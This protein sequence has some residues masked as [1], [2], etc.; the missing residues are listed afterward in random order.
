[1]VSYPELH[2]SLQARL[3]GDQQADNIVSSDIHFKAQRWKHN[4]SAWKKN[5]SLHQRGVKGA[6]KFM[7]VCFEHTQD[8]ANIQYSVLWEHVTDFLLPGVVGE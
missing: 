8:Q 7:V 6:W 2:A 3:G 1:M 5:N 4:Y